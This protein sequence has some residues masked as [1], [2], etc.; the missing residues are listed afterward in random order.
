MPHQLAFAFRD[1]PGEAFCH[2]ILISGVNFTD[3]FPGYKKSV[4]PFG[5]GSKYLADDLYEIDLF[6]NPQATDHELAVFDTTKHPYAKN[7]RRF[8]ICSEC[9]DWGCGGVSARITFAGDQVL[10]SDFEGANFDANQQALSFVFD[11]AQYM[12]AFSELRA[13]IEKSHRAA[14]T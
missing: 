13:V 12:G 10:W 11:R 2:D 1:P 8:L 4:T 9:H 3:Y 14:L 6:T 5:F 7:A